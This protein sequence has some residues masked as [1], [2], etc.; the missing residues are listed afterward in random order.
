[1]G[2]GGGGREGVG[3]PN[4]CTT[5]AS[6]PRKYNI[7]HCPLFDPRHFKRIELFSSLVETPKIL[8]ALLA[9]NQITY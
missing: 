7:Q 1:M 9:E 2:G 6:E 5:G 4:P 3:T 8:S